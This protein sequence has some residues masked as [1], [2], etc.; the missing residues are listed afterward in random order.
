MPKLQLNF[1]AF[2]CYERASQEAGMLSF[3]PF[4]ASVVCPSGPYL[5]YNLLEADF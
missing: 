1:A 3:F 5:R 4:W 2:P